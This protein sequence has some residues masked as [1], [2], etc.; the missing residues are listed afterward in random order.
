MHIEVWSDVVCPFCFLGKRRLEKALTGFDRAAEVTITWRS[1]Q[2]DPEHPR[3]VNTPT[4]DSLV[5]KFGA[6]LVQIEALNARVTAQAAEEGLDYHLDRAVTANTFDAHRMVHLAASLGLGDA[7]QERLMRAALIDGSA[8]DD[9]DTLIRLGTEVGVPVEEARRVL[10]A[11]EYAQ[12]VR[13]DISDAQALG[14]TGV[15]FFVL[16]RAYG[17]SGAQPVDAFLSALRRAGQDAG[18]A[19]R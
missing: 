8:V 17:V 7:M 16:D 11:D 15:P 1:F 6:P 18:T 4:V 5:R 3:G 19:A 12:D 2:L 13:R 14:I 9:T 10:T